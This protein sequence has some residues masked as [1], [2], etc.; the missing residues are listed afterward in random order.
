MPKLIVQHTEIRKAFAH[1]V[2]SADN[3]HLYNLL[4]GAERTIDI[5]A[6]AQCILAPGYRL[7]RVDHR[8]RPSSDE[9]EI[10]LINDL[11]RSVVYY[12]RVVISNIVDLNCRPATQNLVWRS[13]NA[14]HAAVLRDVAQKVF[15]NYIL[16]RY[17]VILSDNQQ[18]G[19]GKFFWQRQMSNAL[20]LGLHVYY[21][22]M[23]TADLEPINNQ[24]DLNNLEDQLWAED[25]A[26]EYHLALISKV[27]LPAE[28]LVSVAVVAEVD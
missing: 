11:E 25:D 6:D 18:T 23:L 20:A 2:R 28:L 17:D 12:N 24:E 22:Q 19:E 13:A 21:Y 8:V 7:L 1:L 26:Q 4:T 16:D 10:A 3:A 9:F 14:Q 15:F 27:P 5:S